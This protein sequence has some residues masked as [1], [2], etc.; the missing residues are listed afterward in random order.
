MR[1]YVVMNTGIEHGEVLAVYSKYREAVKHCKA[2][3]AAET[4]ERQR[5]LHSKDVQASPWKRKCA[6]RDLRELKEPLRSWGFS[7]KPTLLKFEVK[8]KFEG[9]KLGWY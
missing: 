3:I 9:L 2:I 8:D 7:P 6:T 4:K 5:R 1:V